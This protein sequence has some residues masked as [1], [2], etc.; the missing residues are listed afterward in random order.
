M[1]LVVDA[2]LKASDMHSHSRA[3]DDVAAASKLIAGLPH[4]E[5]GVEETLLALVVGGSRASVLILTIAAG[6]A[7]GTKASKCVCCQRLF[8]PATQRHI[9]DVTPFHQAP[10]LNCDRTCFSQMKE[11]LEQGSVGGPAAVD[12]K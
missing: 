10:K 1:P 2:L 7:R 6:R 9:G 5:T 4:P 12:E 3:V 11:R 8:M